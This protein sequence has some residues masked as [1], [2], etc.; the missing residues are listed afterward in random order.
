M[1]YKF[2][3]LPARPGAIK[4]KFNTYFSIPDLPVP[5]QRIGHELIRPPLNEWGMLANDK[6]GCCVFAGA[7]HEHMVWTHMGSRD[8]GD[9]FTDE[10]V[11]SDYAAVSGY[12]GSKESDQGIDM[13]T[14]AAYR[15]K[16]GIIDAENRRHKIDAYVAL[17]PGNWE[18]LAIAVY[19]MGAVGIGLRCPNNVDTLFDDGKPWDVTPGTKIAGGHYVP[20]ILRNTAN[21]SLFGV[22]TWGGIQGMTQEF[23]AKYNDETVAYV[24]L[25]VLGKQNISPDGFDAPT[26]LRDVTALAI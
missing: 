25:E 24:S 3:K 15:R 18:H 21:P 23:Y 22:V 26:L 4:F 11:L 8:A 17:E 19:L 5:P 16:T 10:N 6:V 20:C 7:A 2:G 1:K 12:D 13:A 14:A 9:N